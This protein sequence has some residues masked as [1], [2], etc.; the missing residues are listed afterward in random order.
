MSKNKIYHKGKKFELPKQ[1]TRY[2]DDDLAL[3]SKLF[4]D[5]LP[6][7]MSLR[8]HFLQGIMTG[9][10]MILLE[11]MAKDQEFMY[12]IQKALLPEIEP[13]LYFHCS[14]DIWVSV[15]T[16][17]PE[18]AIRQMKARELLTKYIKQQIEI[19]KD[20][21]VE[22]KIKF[23]NLIYNSKKKPEQAIIEMDTRNNILKHID[24]NLQDLQIFAIQHKTPDTEAEAKKR[25][26]DSME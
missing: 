11:K 14:T 21:E 12:I 17:D 25:E 20:G 6:L 15:N 23:K 16:E 26:M 13:E 10:E 2:G 9:V 8:K 7:L 24:K 22:E 1:G 3:I 4:L 5:N 18:L 19:L